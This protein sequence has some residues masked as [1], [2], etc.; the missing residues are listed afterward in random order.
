MSYNTQIVSQIQFKEYQRDAAA[1]QANIDYRMAFKRSNY[2]SA[3]VYMISRGKEPAQSVIKRADGSSVKTGGRTLKDNIFTDTVFGYFVG[4]GWAFG[5]VENNNFRITSET[6]VRYKA[7]QNGAFVVNYIAEDDTILT[8]TIVI[9]TDIPA[10]NNLIE[11]DK[12]AVEH[13]RQMQVVN[14]MYKVEKQLYGKSEAD[15]RKKQR[16]REAN[17]QLVDGAKNIVFLPINRQ[18]FATDGA[19]NQARLL[20]FQSMVATDEWIETNLGLVVGLKLAALGDDAIKYLWAAGIGSDEQTRLIR[21]ARQVF[22]GATD[23]ETMANAKAAMKSAHLQQIKDGF[24]EGVDVFGSALGKV[25]SNGD[26][27][28]GVLYSSLLGELGERLATTIT[29]GATTAE[30]Q[31]PWASD[32]ALQSFGAEF[33]ARTKQAAIGAVS[34][35]LSLELGEALGLDGFGAELFGTVGSSVL[36][37]AISNVLNP[38]LG[39]S[40]IFDGFHFDKLADGFGKDLFAK[41]GAGTLAV[42]AV[43]SFLG[44]KLGALVVQPQTQA[45]VALSSIGSAVGAWAFTSAT[46][47]IS[48]AVIGSSIGSSAWI[49]GNVVLPGVGAF[50][51]FVLGALIGNLF[52]RKKPKIP[53]ANAETVLQ[54]PYARYELGAVTVVNNG[55]RSLVTSMATMARDTLNGLISMIAYTNTTAYVS[56]LNGGGT[57]QI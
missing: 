3:Y 48:S 2:S 18:D 54:I 41:G 40:K 13:D 16:E 11:V 43:A 35:L 38:S 22:G 1:G 55:N 20:Q 19:Y 44:S 49:M 28:K 26:T 30:T 33:A 36:S 6:Y 21:I 51:G 47:G 7:A 34:S 4:G 57:T 46:V 56:N 37:K 15:S 53:S 27:L 39:S 52:G 10:Y 8:K 14:E 25:L 32:S 29:G 17:V 23:A 9:G 24:I 31:L 50:V 5:L 42:S 45:A 12:L